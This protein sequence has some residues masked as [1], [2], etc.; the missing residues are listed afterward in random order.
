MNDASSVNAVVLAKDHGLEVILLSGRRRPHV[1]EIAQLLGIDAFAC[2]C[3]GVVVDGHDVRFLTDSC[4]RRSDR[5]VADEVELSGAP[6][7]L[8]R[9]FRGQLERD[10]GGGP[11]REVSVPLRGQLDLDQAH[12]LL[13]AA[14]L[15]HIRVDENGLSRKRPAATGTLARSY[16]LVPSSASKLAAA[17]YYLSARGIDP[18][19]SWAIGDGRSD[20]ELHNAVSHV[21]LVANAGDDEARLASAS[22]IASVSVAEA[23]FGRGVLEV[24]E[25]ITGR[26]THLRADR[27]DRGCDRAGAA[28][29][30]AAG[31][32]PAATPSGP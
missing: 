31:T 27:R 7:L 25:A 32:V 3:G 20:M 24:V 10:A 9:A 12:E 19:Q 2:E 6:D 21:W 15:T 16:Q 17:R 23:P 11:P 22:S 5:S 13:G 30:L 26:T 18:S 28:D 14:G 1:A 8:L 4:E 29:G